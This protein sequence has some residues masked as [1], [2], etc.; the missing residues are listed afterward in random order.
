MNQPIR[1]GTAQ[2]E[3]R[4]GDKQYNL[5]VISKLAHA[6]AAQGAQ[7]ISFHECSIT[8]YTFAKNL[9]KAELLEHCEIIPG[10]KSIQELRQ[11]AAAANIT[12]LAGLFE[13]DDQNNIYK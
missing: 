13:K 8:G 7:V 9:S 2:F 11:I 4:S 1:I 3:N 12:V 5:S 6:A 10:G